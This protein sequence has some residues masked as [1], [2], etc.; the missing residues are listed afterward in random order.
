MN[1]SRRSLAAGLLLCSVAFGAENPPPQAAAAVGLEQYTLK[2]GP[3]RI[4][5]APD[6]C[7]GVTFCP[8]SRTLF[9]IQNKPTRITEL[10][11]D[12][13]PKG[14][15]ELTGFDDTEDLVYLGPTRFAVVEERRRTLCLVSI[16]AA[17]AAAAYGSA[18]KALVDPG[19][20]DN[21][22]LEGVAYDAAGQRFFVVKEKNPR[23]IYTLPL[24]A[25]G[26]KAPAVS[27]P[28]DIQAASLGCDD[29]SGIYYH[30]GTGHLLLLSDESQCVVEATTDGQ[31]VG[32]L[33]LKAGSAGLAEDARQPEG[34]A[35][36]D[37]GRLYICSEPDRLY[38]FAKP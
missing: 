7:S 30:A 15:I 8:E 3:I 37:Q 38:I 36:D 28:W 20:A 5:G 19:E 35:M 9:V 14:R 6:N 33:S 13:R 24:P 22:G 10:D 12:G 4:E 25:P 18:Q 17:A 27:Q 16:P 1:V 23:R 21:V 29:L 11:L 32:R 31:E 2:A 34:I 26:A